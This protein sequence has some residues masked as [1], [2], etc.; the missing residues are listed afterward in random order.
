MNHGS[1]VEC[2]C[3]FP[4]AALY[5]SG[6][7]TAVKVWDLAMTGKVLQ[8]LN[9]AHSKAMVMGALMEDDGRSWF[10]KTGK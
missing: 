8:E 9:D 1:P 2:G 5:A 3:A 10:E 4:G 7:G 6:G